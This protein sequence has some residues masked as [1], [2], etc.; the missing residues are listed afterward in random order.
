MGE[1]RENKTVA[2]TAKRSTL[3][4][5]RKHKSAGLLLVHTS[6][7][8]ESG[9]VDRLAVTTECRVGRGRDAD[10]RVADAR[11]SN[12]HFAV[13]RS[14][15][16][17]YV[18]DLGSTNGTL[19]NGQ[20]VPNGKKV[21]LDPVAVLH[22]G[23]STFVFHAEAGP[24]LDTSISPLDAPVPMAGR[25]HL[26]QFLRELME[27][28]LSD[29]APLLAGPSGVGKEH[30]A[31]SLAHLWGLEK[32]RRYNVASAASPEEMAR[33]LF[34][35]APKAYTGVAEQPGLIVSAARENAPLFLDEVHHLS[36]EAQAT[37]LTVLEDGRFS[38]KG[39]ES[40]EVE[41]RL[42]FVFASN[43]PDKLK[44][45]LRARLWRIEVPSLRARVADVPDI[46]DHLLARLL[47]KRGME[48]E[49]VV[50]VLDADFYHGLCLEAHCGQA[51]AENNVR[52]LLDLADRIVA[53][54]A[55]G[56]P[57]EDAVDSVCKERLAAAAPEPGTDTSQYERH[58]ELISAVYLG[59]G[60]NAR[61][62]V[63]LLRDANVP[64]TIS[65]RH[66]T[67]HVEKWGIK[68]DR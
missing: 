46:F 6:A 57:P 50:E 26:P 20:R 17:Y 2:H 41:V 43:E 56:A 24:I 34:G 64:W 11:I 23:E 3:S 48:A 68:G 5:R 33:T 31:E 38:R 53:R 22:A 62:T 49:R 18:E 67:L 65:R 25:F 27:A 51:F 59:C 35:V 30:A 60:K 14:G 7:A 55:A 45:D 54:I 32:P 44:H 42:R 36:A 66:L 19:L 61:K 37:L 58:R 9:L 29:R 1:H 10:F 21:A 28:A 47:T 63:E 52:G 8:A 12:L 15:A 39:A 13:S 4:S 16:S 40:E